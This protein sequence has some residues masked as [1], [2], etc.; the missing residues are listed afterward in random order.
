MFRPSDL[1]A[2]IGGDE[3]TVLLHGLPNVERADEIA[4]RVT[5]E[6]TRVWPIDG[7]DVALS[8]SVGLAVGRGRSQNASELLRRADQAIYRAKRNGRGRW[9]SFQAAEVHAS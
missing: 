8:V 5:R 6:L 9:E 4:E 3:F 7:H 2:R 1:V